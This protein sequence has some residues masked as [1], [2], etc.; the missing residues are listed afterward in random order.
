VLTEL[1]FTGPVA[2]RSFLL[3]QVR[4]VCVKRTGADLK[5]QSVLGD[6]PSHAEK[7]STMVPQKA[8]FI[9]R[10]NKRTESR[11]FSF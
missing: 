2:T 3:S 6:R 8:G 11:Q 7:W 5:S 1:G 4:T 10:R 9:L